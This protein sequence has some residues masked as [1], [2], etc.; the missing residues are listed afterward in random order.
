[1]S[2]STLGKFWQADFLFDKLKF[3]YCFNTLTE[4]SLLWAS[5]EWKFWCVIIIIAGSSRLWLQ[6]WYLQC[7]HNCYTVGQ[8][9]CSIHWNATH[10]GTTD[11]HSDYTHT[12]Q[13]K[14][15]V[16]I[17]VESVIPL[18]FSSCDGSVSILVYAS[19]YDLSMC[20]LKQR[21]LEKI[22]V[23]CQ[24]QKPLKYQS[25]QKYVGTYSS[26]STATQYP[27]ERVN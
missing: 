4:C 18:M 24:M 5:N 10:Q 12:R 27:E 8:R 11:I 25:G 21:V 6:V 26:S 14:W 17:K 7:W 3:S 9:N 1:M 20:T 19:L 23:L 13:S 22:P 2:C 16:Y 15:K